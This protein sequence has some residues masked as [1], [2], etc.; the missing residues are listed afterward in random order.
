MFLPNEMYSASGFSWAPVTGPSVRTPT[1]RLTGLYF[2]LSSLLGLTDPST[3][4]LVVRRA[5]RLGNRRNAERE[6]E[7]ERDRHA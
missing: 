3:N 6:H 1:N 2:F 5:V 7:A 4:G